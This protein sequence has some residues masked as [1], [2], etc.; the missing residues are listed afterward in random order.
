VLTFVAFCSLAGL[1]I[2]WVVYPLVIAALAS[3]L[4]HRRRSART[5]V[6]YEPWVSVIIATRDDPDTIKRRIANCLESSYDPAKLQVVIAVDRCVATAQW[7]ELASMDDRVTFVRGDEPGGKA[8]ALNAA[9]RAC[10]GNV[11]V[12]GDAHQEWENDAIRHLVA[13]LAR[14]RVG[15]VSGCLEI[16][17]TARRSL[18][19]R[20]WLFERRL[21]C[22][23]AV[24]HSSVGVTG[25]IWAMRTNLWSALPTQLILDDVFTPMQLV[26]RGH[27]VAFAAAARAFETRLHDPTQEYRRKVRTL[28]GVIQLCTWLPEVLSP[29]SNPVWLQFVVHKVMRLLTPYWVAVITAWIAV[30][31]VR[32]IAGSLFVGLAIA[33]GV[34]V[35]AAFAAK[36][37][38]V[39]IA[40]ET[41]VS[42]ALLQAAAVVGTVNGFRGRWNVWHTE[43]SSAGDA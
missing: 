35:V 34:G 39:K 28:T 40:R 37:N 15:A 26:M 20:Y 4:A 7:R 36:S 5:A 30:A 43:P 3:L 9:V 38:V 42:A 29:T 32:S 25:A 27:R 33:L 6:A 10:R 23:E 12:F 1:L 24:V 2:V 18:A 8:A 19:G 31:V 13:A 17:E 11:L 22:C 21:R 16:P 14:P 41:I